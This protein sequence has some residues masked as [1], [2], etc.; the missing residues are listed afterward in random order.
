MATVAVTCD[1]KETGGSLLCAEES[2][3]L[4]QNEVSGDDDA[5]LSSTPGREGRARRLARASHK[6][7]LVA[8]L[9]ANVALTILLYH[10]KVPLRDSERTG[11]NT[12]LT[13]AIREKSPYG[14]QSWLPLP[15]KSTDNAGSWS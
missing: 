2:A 5:A 7:L 13:N 4:I 11:S 3:W 6:L 15:N 9:V 10:M 14:K 1:S 8:S 12:F